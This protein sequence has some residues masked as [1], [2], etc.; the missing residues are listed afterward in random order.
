MS[1]Y[2]C[3]HSDRQSTH[4]L[5]ALSANGRMH[6]IALGR[7]LGE[8][9]VHEPYILSSV[10]E[11]CLETAT[12]ISRT[13]G[14]VPIFVEFGL[15]EGPV[16]EMPSNMT[17]FQ[18]QQK[19]RLVDPLYRCITPPPLGEYT[20]RDVLPRCV[21]MGRFVSD[22]YRKS[23]HKADI[24]VVTHGTVAFGMVA[25]MTQQTH[26]SLDDALKKVHGCV[27]A[28]YYR[29]V[30]CEQTNHGLTWLTDFQCH[31]SNFPGS[32][33]ESG[34]ATTPVCFIPSPA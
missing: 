15:S 29:L 26:E 4:P 19:F 17:L 25:A 23:P 28:G 34:A 12:A 32:S 8:N 10:Y 6:A 13:V 20:Q 1:V 9:G 22:V 31:T 24:V 7:E 18:I 21:E 27:A 16:Q 5:S 30:P 11:R 2:I 3:R 14:R 33:Q